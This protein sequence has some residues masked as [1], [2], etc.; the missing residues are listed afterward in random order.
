MLLLDTFIHFVKKIE[1][2]RQ[3]DWQRMATIGTEVV[4]QHLTLIRRPKWN[5]KYTTRIKI[6]FIIGF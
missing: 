1:A 4:N 5:I 3:M 6:T 2:M